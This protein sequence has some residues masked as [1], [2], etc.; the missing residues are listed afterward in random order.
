MVGIITSE[1]MWLGNK[2]GV[3]PTLIVCAFDFCLPCQSSIVRSKQ[4]LYLLLFDVLLL[5]SIHF[6]I[7]SIV[8]FI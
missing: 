5:Q 4:F 6:L 8:A 1:S 3:L 7:S 2:I